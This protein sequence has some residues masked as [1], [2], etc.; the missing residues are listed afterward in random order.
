MRRRSRLAAALAAA[1]V[2]L[3][4]LLLLLQGP[5]E[6]SAAADGPPPA[7]PSTPAPLLP[8]PVASPVRAGARAPADP[9]AEA[10]GGFSG[11]VLSAAGGSPIPGAELTFALGGAASAVHTDGTGAFRFE[12]PFR[13]LWTLAAASAVG[14]LPF[15]PEWGTS[16]VLLDA[17]PGAFVTGIEV[18]L[19]PAVRYRGLVI[20]PAGSPVPGAEVRILGAASG[21]SALAP[22]RERHASGPDGTFAFE[23]PDGAWLEARAAGY[24]PGRAVLD[25]EVR[26]GRRLV[27]RLGA[28]GERSSA[29]LAIAGTV[30]REGAGPLAGALVTATGR[31]AEL[32]AAQAVTD[33]DGRF[34][35]RELPDGGYRV[36]ASAPGLAP[37]RRVAR[38]GADD[39][40]FRLSP[41]GSLAGRVT[42]RHSGAPVAPF[43]VTVLRPDLRR[44]PS[45]SLAVIDAEGRFAIDGLAP[46]PAE[47]VVSAP[48]H[49]PSA[50]QPV[51]IPDGGAPATVEVRLSPPAGISGQVRDRASRR[52]I[53]GAEVE[54][55]G[56]AD[57]LAIFPVRQ[58]AITDA[59]GGF[60]L[61]GLPEGRVS[62]FVR[63]D[64]HHARIVGGIALREGQVAGPVDID[65]SPVA[66]GEEPQL[67]MA[68]IG[69]VLEP[70]E[71]GLRL[72]RL[73]EGGGA[74]EAG[75]QTGDLILRVDGRPVS[76]LGFP[77]AIQALRGPEDS[78][79]QLL[80]RRPGPPASELSLTVYRRLFRR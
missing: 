4:I 10:R 60:A 58:R 66:P 27:L 36:T 11:R 12:P 65:L 26:A 53:A 40:V 79:V 28:A 25:R 46:G 51:T 16:P 57:R 77:N 5:G 21:D 50:P 55:E 74:A 23:A 68:G 70:G 15:A 8:G 17:R 2:A 14:F 34:A 49:A 62:L 64:G 24:S 75:L 69:V 67:E 31:G 38:A 45:R 22:L 76:E 32:P 48:S 6:P 7:E 44:E 19:Q 80:V 63:A 56:L 41:G 72:R 18:V 37:A 35:L 30:E 20:D 61:S 3:A 13:G 1:A 43:V 78:A 54:A 29:L 47:L 71:E 33:A 73:V 39:L 9:P 52:P 59:H 42:D